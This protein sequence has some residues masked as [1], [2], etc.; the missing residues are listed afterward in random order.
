MLNLCQR[1]ILIDGEA[2][3]SR[4]ADRAGNPELSGVGCGSRHRGICASVVNGRAG[5]GQVYPSLLRGWEW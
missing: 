1:G 3:K 5:A 4:R 2:G